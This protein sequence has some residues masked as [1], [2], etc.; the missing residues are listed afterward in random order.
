MEG[1]Q[2]LETQRL[3]RAWGH[4]FLIENPRPTEPGGA[5]P[6]STHDSPARRSRPRSRCP[7]RTPKSGEC[8]C[9]CHSESQAGSR[10]AA[11][12]PRGKERRKESVWWVYLFRQ[13][14]RGCLNYGPSPDSSACPQPIEK[15]SRN[16]SKEERELAGPGGKGCTRQTSPRNSKPLRAVRRTRARERSVFPPPLF[17][18]VK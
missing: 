15:L 14:P 10:W 4:H 12:S 5:R 11:L 16:C 7:H 18:L 2:E 8:T 17:P 1:D 3:T 13:T 6:A 9:H